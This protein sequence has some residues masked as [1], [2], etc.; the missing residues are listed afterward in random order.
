MRPLI[1]FA[2]I[3]GVSPSMR[4]SCAGSNGFCGEIQGASTAARIIATATRVETIATGE[5]RKLH[6]KS[7]SQ[8]RARKPG[9]GAGGAPASAASARVGAGAC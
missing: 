7:E 3:G 8:A 9:P 6:R 5:W 2:V 4:S 1:S